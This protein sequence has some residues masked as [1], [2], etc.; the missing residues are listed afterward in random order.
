MTPDWLTHDLSIHYGQRDASDMLSSESV[1]VCGSPKVLWLWLVKSVQIQITVFV[2]WY[3][4]VLQEKKHSLLGQISLNKYA[5]YRWR[6]VDTLLRCWPIN[7][8]FLKTVFDPMDC[9]NN[10]IDYVNGWVVLHTLVH[11]K[12]AT[13]FP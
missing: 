13:L 6:L 12:L 5:L 2:T 4:V 10:D 7:A 8:S 11:L 3:A 9:K 1:A